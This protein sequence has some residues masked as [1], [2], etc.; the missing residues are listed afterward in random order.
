MNA[1]TL[2][3]HLFLKY[4]GDFDKI[5]NHLKAKLELELSQEEIEKEADNFIAEQ[6]HNGYEVVTLI[7]EKCDWKFSF[8]PDFLRLIPIETE[9]EA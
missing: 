4:R 3:I 8:R 9:G 1:R 2:I 6:E 7:D 5:Y